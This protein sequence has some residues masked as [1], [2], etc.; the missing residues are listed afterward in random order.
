MANLTDFAKLIVQGMYGHIGKT[1]VPLFHLL[2][3]RGNHKIPST[4]AIF[5]MSAAHDCISDLLGLCKAKACGVRCYAKH[6]ELFRPHTMTYRRRQEKFWLKVTA[7][8]FAMQFLLINAQKIKSPFNALRFNE[9]GDFHSQE[10]VDKAE[11]IARILKRY[12]IVTYCYTSRDDLDYSKVRALRVSGS[13]FKK[14]GIANIFQIIQKKED[15]PKGYGLCPMDCHICNR[16][17]RTGMKTAVV[18]H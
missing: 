8:E 12:G 17:Q 13:G 4:T 2:C 1:L 15:R 5:N 9:S 6:T 18:K 11:K 3:E 16:C 10:C 14:K 7:E